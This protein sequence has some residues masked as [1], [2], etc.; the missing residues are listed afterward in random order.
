MLLDDPGW[1]TDLGAVRESMPGAS[2][3][4][5]GGLVSQTLIKYRIIRQ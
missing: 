2:A 1:Y 4:G 3:G 5:Q